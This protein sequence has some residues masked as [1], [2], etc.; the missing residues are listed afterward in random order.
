MT[1]NGIPVK[2]SPWIQPD[3]IWHMFRGDPVNECILTD[4]VD[5]IVRAMRN[6]EIAV[7]RVFL[8]SCGIDPDVFPESPAQALERFRQEIQM[9][10]H[11]SLIETALIIFTVEQLGFPDVFSRCFSYWGNTLLSWDIYGHGP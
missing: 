3:T 11:A 2:L 4:S 5:T 8:K 9:A 10:T 7:D 1:L 6:Y